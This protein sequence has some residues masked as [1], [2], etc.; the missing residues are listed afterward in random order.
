MVVCSSAGVG[1]IAPKLEVSCVLIRMFSTAVTAV[2]GTLVNQ[3]KKRRVQ[4][5]CVHPLVQGIRTPGHVQLLLF[6]IHEI[7]PQANVQR[8]VDEHCTDVTFLPCDPRLI[9]PN[10][11]TSRGVQTGATSIK[12]DEHTAHPA[13]EHSENESLRYRCQNFSQQDTNEL[14]LDT[15]IR[16]HDRQG[17][18]SI[19]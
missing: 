13:G 9:R 15:R 18:H 7:R 11:G 14:R 1:N 19:W 12:S 17:I 8:V 6:R 4:R 10:H 5:S 3:E 2:L 16:M